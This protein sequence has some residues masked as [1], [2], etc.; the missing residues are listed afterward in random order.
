MAI[1]LPKRRIEFAIIMMC[2]F[3]R[4]PFISIY[5][6]LSYVFVFFLH[7]GVPHKRFR[8]QL[9]MLREGR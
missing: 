7:A 6:I 1:H 5:H 3:Q 8:Q 4:A 9:T 2:V